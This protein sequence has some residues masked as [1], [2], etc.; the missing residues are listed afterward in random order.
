MNQIPKILSAIFLITFLSCKKFVEVPPPNTRLVGSTVYSSNTT[1]AAAVTGIYQSM[2]STLIGGGGQ[3]ISAILG[4]SADEFTLFPNL[5]TKINQVYTNSLNS[6]NLVPI[7]EPLYNYIYQS[8]LAIELLTNN[9]SVTSP[10]K[11][12][13]LGEAKFIRAFCYLYLNH[14]FGDVPLVKTTDYVN[15]SSISR[16]PTSDVYQQIVADLNDAILLLPADYVNGNGE[17][18]LERVRPNKFAAKAILSRALLY[19]EN[20]SAAESEATDIINDNKFILQTDLTKVFTSNNSEAIFQLQSPNNGFNAP[21][22]AFLD[23]LLFYG[24]P[25]PYAP[26]LLNDSLVNSFDASDLRRQHWITQ[27]QVGTKTYYYPYKYKLSYT[28]SP[29]TEYPVLIRLAEIYLIRSE[30][31]LNQGNIPGALEDLNTI[32]SR[33]GLT[34]ITTSNAE[35]LKISILKERQHELF[36]EYGHRWIDLKRSKKLDE[37]MKKATQ[38]KGGIWNASDNLFPIPKTEILTNNRLVQNP[39]Y[40]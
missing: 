15:N 32:R 18:V 7:W 1:A 37:V 23:G 20:W 28:G 9:K 11:E 35:N 3:G 2:T 24:G 5:D 17:P 8:N 12:Q 27:N 16:T 31:R 25:Q 38:L 4:L 40:N 26:F 10:L 36:T 29:P 39:G 21:D 22:G 13:L 6:G 14:F 19:Q 34:K 30:C 33:A